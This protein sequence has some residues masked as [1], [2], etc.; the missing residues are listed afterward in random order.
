MKALTVSS[1]FATFFSA[2]FCCKLMKL[3]ITELA[4]SFQH[5]FAFLANTYPFGILSNH[6]AFGVGKETF[7]L[8]LSFIRNFC[9]PLETKYLPSVFFLLAQKFTS[10]CFFLSISLYLVIY[11]GPFQIFTCVSFYQ[12]VQ[13]C[14]LYFLD[15]K[16]LP[17][18]AGHSWTSRPSCTCKEAQIP[19]CPAPA[20]P[21][22]N[23][24]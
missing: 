8:F 17:V 9:A 7:L 5:L 6:P 13:P 2:S 11:L 23:P 3:S 1:Y 18:S 10:F 21:P 20:P 16:Y 4:V 14:F 12:I 19:S 24:G 15:D 22:Q